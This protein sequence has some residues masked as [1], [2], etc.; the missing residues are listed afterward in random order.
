VEEKR[1]ATWQTRLMP[2]FRPRQPQGPRQIQEWGIELI[3]QLAISQPQSQWQSQPQPWPRLQ[4]L[5][6]RGRVRRPTTEIEVEVEADEEKE[7]DPDNEEIRRDEEEE[8]EDERTFERNEEVYPRIV[9]RMNQLAKL[10]KMYKIGRA[11][12][13]GPDIESDIE[14]AEGA[15]ADNFREDPET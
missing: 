1:R 2:E 9:E 5:Q 14:E 7:T 10:L 12:I 11:R 13:L 8:P 15:E 3:R 6:R 4:P